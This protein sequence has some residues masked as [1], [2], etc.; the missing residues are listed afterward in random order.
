MEIGSDILIIRS[1][2]KVDPKS[3]TALWTDPD[4]THYIG[5]K[6]TFAGES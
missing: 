1:I 2:Q 5:G 6:V 3:L 4:I